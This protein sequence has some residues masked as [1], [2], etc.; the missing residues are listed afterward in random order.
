MSTVA[1]VVAVVAL[2]AT[3]LT[4]SAERIDRLNLRVERADASLDAQLVR[5]SAAADAFAVHARAAGLLPDRQLGDLRA[6][7]AAALAASAHTGHGDR[8]ATE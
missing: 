5:R 4:W 7:T 8:W 2:L 1:A 6:V 3:Y